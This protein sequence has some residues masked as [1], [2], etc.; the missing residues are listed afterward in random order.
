VLDTF[1]E[2]AYQYVEDW[3]TDSARSNQGRIAVV[4]LPNSGK[5]SLVNSL[6]GWNAVGESEENTQSYGLI[7]IIN[8]P[9]DNYDAVNTLYRLESD[10]SESDLE[11]K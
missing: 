11:L 3:A 2:N 5:K 7:Q 8:L 4:G 10:S 9:Q 6:Y 1:Y